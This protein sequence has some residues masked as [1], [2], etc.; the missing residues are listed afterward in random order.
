ML[1]SDDD[2][3]EALGQRAYQITIPYFTWPRRVTSFLQE[4]GVELAWSDL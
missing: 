3:R 4:L 1:L 2:L